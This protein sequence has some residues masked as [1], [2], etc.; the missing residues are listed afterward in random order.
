[1]ASG[2]APPWR[3]RG[4]P[5]RSGVVPCEV[6]KTARSVPDQAPLVAASVAAMEIA[7][8][9]AAPARRPCRGRARPRWPLLLVLVVRRAPALAVA[10]PL[11]GRGR[12]PS[13]RSSSV[14]AGPAQRRSSL[15]EANPA[16]DGSSSPTHQDRGELLARGHRASRCVTLVGV[17]SLGGPP[18]WPAAAAS[19]RAASSCWTRSL[20]ALLVVAAVALSSRSS[21]PATP[22]LAPSGLTS[23][24]HRVAE[25]VS[26]VLTRGAVDAGLAG[27]TGLS[28][29][30]RAPGWPG[31]A[32][33]SSTRSAS[34]RPS[35]TASSSAHSGSVSPCVQP[36]GQ[37]SVSSSRSGKAPIS[38][39]GLDVREP[40]RAD[41]GGVDDPAARV[42]SSGSGSISADVEVCRPRPVTALTRPI[43][44]SVPGHQRV[45]QRGLADAAVPDQHAD[46]APQPVAD[47]GEVGAA[48]GHDVGHAERP[49]DRQ[50]RLRVG[51]VGLGQAQQRVH[52]RRRTPRRGP[53]RSA[54]AGARGRRARRPPRAGRRWRR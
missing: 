25:R 26:A 22:A 30:R 17:W 35:A 47:L 36:R 12:L 53:G 42:P 50:Q 18:R 10:D 54:A 15:L 40:E 31:A 24:L 19:G 1:M 46:P 34:V 32:G 2:Y 3:M 4:A 11:A 5:A 23:H 9:A 38:S 52:A 33:T 41:A 28:R 39:A 14:W 45:D 49:V 20:P 13:S 44:R 37:S 6:V 48:L 8:P 27:S 43:A 7:R 16:A 29:R 51:E 21:S